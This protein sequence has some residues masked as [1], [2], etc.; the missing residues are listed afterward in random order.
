[1]IDIHSLTRALPVY[2]LEPQTLAYISSFPDPKNPQK[3]EGR[4]VFDDI[5]FLE[6]PSGQHEPY[7]DPLD[8]MQRIFMFQGVSCDDALKLAVVEY[9]KIRPSL[10]VFERPIFFD[11]FDLN[12]HEH[13][14]ILT[15]LAHMRE[16]KLA[17]DHLLDFFKKAAEVTQSIP[18]FADWDGRHFCH[19][20]I[21]LPDSPSPKAMI[22]FAPVPWTHDEDDESIFW[23]WREAMKPIA[24]SLEE[25]LGE[26]VYNFQDL[27]DELDDDCV[28][29][30]LKLYWC[31][32]YKP[33]SSY[34]RYLVEASGATSVDEL[35]AALIEPANYVQPF[36]MYYAFFRAEALAC[37]LMTY[38]PIEKR[39]V[40]GVVFS[41]TAARSVAESILLQQIGASV[42]IAAPEE[43]LFDSSISE[44]L[45]RN[46]ILKHAM[47]FCR[48]DVR[49]HYLQGREIERPIEFLARIDKL[50]IIADT[51]TPNPVFDL[52]LSGSIEEL[53]WKALELNVPTEYYH[54][55]GSHLFNPE[56][57]L[58]KLGVPA[59]V[60]AQ[61]KE[62]ETYTAKLTIL[63]LDCDW[64]SSGLWNELGQMIPYDNIDL[65][66]P[67][68]RRIIDWHE[69]FDATLNADFS[70]EWDEKHEREKCEIARE[71][72]R[73]LGAG[74]VVQVMTDLGW[75]AI[76]ELN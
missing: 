56:V 50:F 52:K 54:I 28:H 60:A 39:Q 18:L 29:R 37:R 75:T 1:L 21:D 16:N 62:R 22:E 43:L 68:I 8:F 71:L 55:D 13:I 49:I 30:F 42:V 44:Y 15:L 34:V 35:K 3:V 51:I 69:E 46:S 20:L 61:D 32:S 65:P 76:G 48:Q 12:A 14:S 47:R 24:A 57:C 38:L 70:D 59:R 19:R 4:Y 2:G 11:D 23:T 74:V 66:L 53:L 25:A 5:V 27:G 36:E 17:S 31:C 64:S 40:V 6:P 26:S 67:L 10:S 73:T 72:Q 9:S 45:I 63:R 58:K 41:T 7:V 33:D